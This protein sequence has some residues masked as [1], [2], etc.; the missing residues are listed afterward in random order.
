MRS[1]LF[2]CLAICLCS[3]RAASAQAVF[4]V[5][6]SLLFRIIQLGALYTQSE[7]TAKCAYVISTICICV[8]FMADLVKE[9]ADIIHESVPTPDQM[10][11]ITDEIFEANYEMPSGRGGRNGGK[12]GGKNGGKNGGKGGSRL[13]LADMY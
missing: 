4:V 7:K 10:D 6:V 2:W 11:E 1:S 13:L 12:D 3:M 5:Y 9:E 8:L